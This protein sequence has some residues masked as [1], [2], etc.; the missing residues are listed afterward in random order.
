VASIVV[1]ASDAGVR[2]LL[3]TALHRRFGAD[4]AVAG[5]SG[6]LRAFSTP[7]GPSVPDQASPPNSSRHTASA[8][9]STTASESGSSPVSRRHSGPSTNIVGPAP[10]RM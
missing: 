9:A 2:D 3:T 4:Y 10:V 5:L 8:W 1:V 6:A 7:E